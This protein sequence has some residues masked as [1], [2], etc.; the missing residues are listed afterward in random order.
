ME[1]DP[2]RLFLLKVNLLVQWLLN[3]IRKKPKRF[4]INESHRVFNP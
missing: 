3:Q 1:T 4:I 2:N